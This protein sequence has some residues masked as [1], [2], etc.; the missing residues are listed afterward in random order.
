MTGRQRLD[1]HSKRS[2][3]ETATDATRESVRGARTAT[4]KHNQD[5]DTGQPLVH[6]QELALVCRH[7]VPQ[8]LQKATVRPRGSVPAAWSLSALWAETRSAF[9]II[10]GFLPCA[11][12]LL[13]WPA[14]RSMGM[15]L[16]LA[17]QRRGCRRCTNRPRERLDH[18]AEHDDLLSVPAHRPSAP[19]AYAATRGRVW[20]YRKPRPPSPGD[21]SAAWL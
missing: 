18:L 9:C 3:S 10:G 8:S 13:R 14:W 6:I 4:A 20:E 17:V 21:R 2:F 11:R 1:D 7:V 19:A 15:P 12:W 5:K 16:R